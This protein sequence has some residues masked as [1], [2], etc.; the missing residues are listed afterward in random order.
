MPEEHAV[1]HDSDAGPR[2]LRDRESLPPALG[3]R[4]LL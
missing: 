2:V 3:G 1:R 4:H